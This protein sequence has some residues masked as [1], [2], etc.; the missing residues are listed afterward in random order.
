LG[1][2]T[3]LITGA[4]GFI[5]SHLVDYL[6]SAKDRTSII[7]VDNFYH[8]SQ[9]NIDRVLR[10]EKVDFIEADVNHLDNVL[11]NESSVDCIIHLSA[12]VSVPFSFRDPQTTHNY[13]VNGFLKILE[14]ARAKNVRKVIYASSSAIYGNSE[15]QLLSEQD[16]PDP[17]SP[18]AASK[19]LNEYYA[20][21]YFEW[22]GVSSI[23]LRFFN[24][25]GP[26]QVADSP[27]SGVISIFREK[28]M[29]DQPVEIFGSGDQV[30]DFI[31]VGDIIKA[32]SKCLQLKNGTSEVFNL[33]TGTPTSIN[34][35]FRTMS[36]LTGYSKDPVYQEVREGD[37]HH[38]RADISKIK[39]SL[40]FEPK[41]TLKS[42]L[43]TMIDRAE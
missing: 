40:G 17:A 22:Y 1:H 13:N 36:D 41:F 37:I 11:K 29:K 39:T 6:S 28:M 32:I 26:G 21:K 5:G 2:Q 33:G 30:R 23:G 43:E 27:Y 35:L 7:A 38:S 24:V 8:S 9:Q 15:N 12:L 10:N 20:R 42:G 34:K 25:F 4:T 31:Y 3:L 14:I 18:Y 16:Q 19:L